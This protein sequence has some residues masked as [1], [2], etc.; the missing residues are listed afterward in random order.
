MAL[1]FACKFFS[2]TLFIF[3]EL[4]SGRFWG[5]IESWEGES[6][7][8]QINKETGSFFYKKGRE[9]NNS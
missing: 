3:S 9:N 4:L 5:N 2:D 7:K 6:K 1:N 8:L